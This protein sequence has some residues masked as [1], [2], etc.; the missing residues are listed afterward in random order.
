MLRKFKD[1][2]SKTITRWETFKTG[3]IRY[4]FEPDTDVL[5]DPSFGGHLAAV[6]KAVEELKELR[7]RLQHQTNMFEK[8]T[9]SVKNL[10]NVL[11]LDPAN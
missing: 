11:M 4:F 3:E 6:D 7:E 10:I 8:M 1:H 5:A 2:L 9:N